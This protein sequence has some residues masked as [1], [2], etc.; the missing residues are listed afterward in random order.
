MSPW[1]ASPSR[2][3]NIARDASASSRCRSSATGGPRPGSAPSGSFLFVSSRKNSIALI[4]G[5]RAQFFVTGLGLPAPAELEH[6]QERLL[7]HLDPAHL[8][9][10]L[11][12][13]PLPLEQLAL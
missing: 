5:P 1:P 9:H 13:R 12:P 7:R 2:S 4:L 10:P 8:L 11:L 6:R 3:P